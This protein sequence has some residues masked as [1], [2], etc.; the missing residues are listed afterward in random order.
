MTLVTRESAVTTVAGVLALRR[1]ALDVVMGL[2]AR[3]IPTWNETSLRLFLE[4]ERCAV[5]LM[6]SLDRTEFGDS[7]PP[8]VLALIADRADAERRRI[9]S[10]REHLATVAQV[11]LRHGWRVVVLKGG[12][13]AAMEE[14]PVDL[15]DIDLLVEPEGA[16]RLAAALDR[17]GYAVVGHSSPRHLTAR[18]KKNGIPVEIHT[19]LSRDGAPLAA[20]VWQRIEVLP[21]SPGL[22]RLA[23]SDHLWHM[24]EHLV[25]DH[26]E[27]RPLFRELM[28]LDAAIAQCD[29]QNLAAVNR[30]I[31]AHALGEQFR[32]VY[33]AAEAL[34]AGKCD[35][36]WLDRL[37]AVVYA[38]RLV[39][40]SVPLPRFLEGY[41]YRW[42]FGWLMGRAVRRGLREEIRQVTLDR[43]TEHLVAHLERGLPFLARPVRVTLRLV[44]AIIAAAMALPAAATAA[45]V[46]RAAR[47]RSGLWHC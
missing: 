10:A 35:S 19:T 5:R 30:R 7:V 32:D 8:E 15:V 9:R 46:A 4:A 45:T 6:H 43:S 33:D 1:W 39:L 17:D 27:R 42:T 3:A 20:E 2:S 26:P 12:I 11:A 40:L 47:A 37:T 24:L 29:R 31:E 13:A 38:V 44:R 14:Q 16:R 23:W 25:L 22:Y 28:L 34:G 18:I 21:R 41:V 36:E